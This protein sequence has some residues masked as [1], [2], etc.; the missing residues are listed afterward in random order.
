MVIETGASVM[1]LDFKDSSFPTEA[2]FTTSRNAKI[3]LLRLHPNIIG[4]P[5]DD[6]SQ[7]FGSKL[8]RFGVLPYQLNL[9]VNN[10]KKTELSVIGSPRAFPVQPGRFYTIGFEE[11]GD[12]H[13]DVLKNRVRQYIDN[14]YRVGSF[15]AR[16]DF[17]NVPGA[18]HSYSRLEVFPNKKVV[19][20]GDTRGFFKD[21]VER[22]L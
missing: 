11:V 6:N 14:G 9:D 2:F 13:F 17:K 5:V 18:T 1:E 20:S 10:L 4:L 15:S 8:E 7:D 19:I 21:L 16:L 3:Y 12:D 22:L